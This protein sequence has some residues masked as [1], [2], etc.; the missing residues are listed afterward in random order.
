[1]ALILFSQQDPRWAKETLGNTPYTIGRWGCLM[2]CATM[3]RDYIFGSGMTPSQV[4]KKLKYTSGGLLI[5]S[6]LPNIGMKLVQRVY[7]NDYNKLKSVYY[8]SDK[9]A[10]LQV[11]SNHWVWVIGRYIPYLGWKIADPWTG[12][13]TYTNRY[14]NKITGFAVVSKS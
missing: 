11:N 9:Y 3:A 1:M 13:K 4:N 14:G 6:S 5:W 10:I 8:S 7:R 2:T 12:T